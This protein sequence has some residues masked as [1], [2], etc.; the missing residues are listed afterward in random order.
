M[1]FMKRGIPRAIA[2]LRVYERRTRSAGYFTFAVTHWF[3]K[4]WKALNSSTSLVPSSGP[5]VRPFSLWRCL[6]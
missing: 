1:K 6:N 2:D 3:A 4:H 5:Y